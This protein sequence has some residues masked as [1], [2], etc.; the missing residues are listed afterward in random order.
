L[1]P[2]GHPVAPGTNGK[3]VARF[4][5]S[6]ESPARRVDSTRSVY[7]QAGRIQVHF[8]E[9]RGGGRKLDYDGLLDKGAVSFYMD[10]ANPSGIAMRSRP[11]PRRL[12]GAALLLAV[13][14]LP[15][16]L[17]FYSAAPI[18]NK[19]C[20]CYDGT[21][22]Q[23]G[24]AQAVSDGTPVLEAFPLKVNLPQLVGALTVDPHHSRAPPAL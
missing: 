21:R 7:G 24:S 19:T 16:H 8:E 14:L 9:L 4:P 18:V 15:F 3:R 6:R 23:V 2:D 13:F 11:Y 10:S 1:E 17:H 22:A 12:T 20:A 5:S